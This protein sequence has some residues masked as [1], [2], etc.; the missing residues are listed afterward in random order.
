MKL[1]KLCELS[2]PIDA[3]KKNRCVCKNCYNARQRQKY[4]EN[5]GHHLA[6]LRKSRKKHH[7]KRRDYNLKWKNENKEK[8]NETQKKWVAAN[9]EKVLLHA[10]NGDFRRR[11]RIVEAGKFSVTSK[12]LLRILS[13]P[14]Y[15]CGLSSEHIDHIIP[16]SRNG[17]HSIGNLAGMCAKCNMSKRSKFYA[18]FR[19]QYLLKNNAAVLSA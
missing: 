11:L 14:C 5:P 1:C 6:Q 15:H 13:K 4:S 9:R 12:D 7:E 10:R 8:V 2:K 16:L 19:Y 17:R 18:E 3:F